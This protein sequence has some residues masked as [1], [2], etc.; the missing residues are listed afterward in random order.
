[1]AFSDRTP[2]P[3]FYLGMLIFALIGGGLA[4]VY[5][6]AVHHKAFFL[7]VGAPALIYAGIGVADS[8]LSERGTVPPLPQQAEKATPD[9]NE[10]I[11]FLRLF[12]NRAYADDRT[13]PTPGEASGPKT[14]T[15]TENPF[16]AEREW[17][18][19]LT[20]KLN[21]KIP[22]NTR[23]MLAGAGKTESLGLPAN[24]GTITLVVPKMTELVWLATDSG[25][26]HSVQ[27]PAGNAPYRLEARASEPGWTGFYQAVGLQKLAEAKVLEGTQLALVP[28]PCPPDRVRIAGDCVVPGKTPT[29]DRPESPLPSKDPR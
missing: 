9:G 19:L 3:S 2:R 21:G 25:A 15:S 28:D 7:G 12:A 4:L 29:P 18:K 8:S 20:V 13:P 26:T 17:G 14:D 27:V 16:N 23:L 5:H 6:E 11:P 1:M 10:L 24:G 22:E